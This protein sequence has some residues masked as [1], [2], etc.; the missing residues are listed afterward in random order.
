[1]LKNTSV[2]LSSAFKTEARK[3]TPGFG[4][5]HLAVRVPFGCFFW[6]YR[7]H[8]AECLV[9]RDLRSGGQQLVST[10]RAR[11]VHAHALQAS[12]E[13]GGWGF[14]LSEEWVLLVWKRFYN[15]DERLS[16]LTCMFTFSLTM[17]AAGDQFPLPPST[18]SFA[19]D[20]PS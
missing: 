19:I 10:R 11:P 12:L 5:S 15:L 3:V 17:I 6:L 4:C 2:P 9:R 1:M 7:H 14:T 20:H 8:L 13:G 18:A 16:L